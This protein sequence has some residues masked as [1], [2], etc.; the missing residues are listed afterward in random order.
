MIDNLKNNLIEEYFMDATYL[1]VPPNVHKFKLLVLSGYYIDNKSTNIYCF[2]LVMNEKYEKFENI[3][4]YLKK[5]Y[6][7]NPKN[8][9]ADFRT[10]QIKAIQ[11]CFP[12]CN[13]HCSFFHFSQA[14]WRN[15]KK[16]G[17]SGKG[18]YSKNHELLLNLQCLCFIK[19]EKIDK[20]YK[21]IQ[22]YYKSEKYI[23]FFAYFTRT[24]MGNRIPKTLWN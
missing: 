7:F 14:I 15:F 18:T 17:L 24:W 13:V 16:C 12:R 5:N 22:K 1:Y 8:F 9:M 11:K 4:E 20:M 10:S 19:K 3:F 2:I 6:Q 23:K 21:S